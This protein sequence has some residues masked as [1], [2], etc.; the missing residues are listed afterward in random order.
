MTIALMIVQN[1]I[2][3]NVVMEV[4]DPTSGSRCDQQVSAKMVT[5]A[6][7]CFFIIIF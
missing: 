4:C 3:L 6:A 5:V 7:R 1:G 2:V